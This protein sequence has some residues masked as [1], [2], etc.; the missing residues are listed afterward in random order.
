M[1]NIK[2]TSNQPFSKIFSGLIWKI[3]PDFKGLKVAIELRD[4][5]QRQVSFSIID[6]ATNMVLAENIQTEEP[7]YFGIETFYKDILCLH[8]YTNESLPEHKGI[9][10]LNTNGTKIWENYQLSYYQNS[11]EGIIAYNPKIEPRRYI[12]LDHT[13][14]EQKPH[15]DLLIGE[16]ADFVNSNQELVFPKRIKTDDLQLPVYL[17]EGIE[18]EYLEKNGNRI[19][20]WYQKT[21]S[22]LECNLVIYGVD[23]IVE[24]QDKIIAGIQNK[25]PS[26]FFVWKNFLIYIKNRSEFVSYLL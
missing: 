23:N 17:E 8:G 2:Y 6:L 18:V 26:S 25:L 13:T 11:Y 19:I 3:V 14:G 10:A 22:M 21:G 12:L 1:I 4:P 24:Y 7:W 16:N 5:T 15:L 20:A 9:V